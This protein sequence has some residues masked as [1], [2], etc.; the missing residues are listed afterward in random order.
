ME[1]EKIDAS[2]DRMA[3]EAKETVALLSEKIDTATRCGRAK[4]KRAKYS[5]KKALLQ[6]TDAVQQQVDESACRI[7]QKLE[8]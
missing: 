1:T 6:A 7:R 2:I 5:A 4:I 3:D 8:E